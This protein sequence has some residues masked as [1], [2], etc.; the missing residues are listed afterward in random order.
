MN[1]LVLENGVPLFLVTLIQRKIIVNELNCI[2]FQISF[3]HLSNLLLKTNVV[4]HLPARLY[5]KK[6]L[7]QVQ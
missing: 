7:P 4:A 3:F 6:F 5:L 1:Y 2:L